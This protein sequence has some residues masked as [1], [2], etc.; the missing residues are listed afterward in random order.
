MSAVAYSL[1]AVLLGW[2]VYVQAGQSV[3]R[4]YRNQGT[5]DEDV[6]RRQTNQ[7]VSL[8]HIPANRQELE[9]LHD[10]NVAYTNL[11]VDLVCAPSGCARDPIISMA[12]RL[13]QP[14]ACL[15]AA[16][17]ADHAGHASPAP[18]NLL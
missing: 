5:L 4:L 6:D 17:W 14:D 7:L 8:V 10:R 15:G 2:C 13:E 3:I 9:M 18:H 1:W 11:H 16:L 12:P